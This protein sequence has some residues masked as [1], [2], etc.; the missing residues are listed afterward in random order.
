MREISC[1]MSR[2]KNSKEAI[3]RD[4]QLEVQYVQKRPFIQEINTH[5]IYSLPLLHNPPP[6]KVIQAPLTWVAARLDRYTTAPAI[7]SGL[8]SLPLGFILA[9]ASTPP[10]LSISPEA[11][12]E[13]KKP[14]AML[15]QRMCR[16][17]NSTA[18]L[19]VRWI[20]AAMEEVERQLRNMDR[21]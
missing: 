1:R 21:G 6:S 12:L 13:G 7:S 5:T 18:R 15:L 20:A 2:A 8:P 17:P 9:I 10:C 11:I 16:G 3:A 4:T 19:R 14:G